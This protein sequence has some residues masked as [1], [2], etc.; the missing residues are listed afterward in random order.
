MGRIQRFWCY[1]VII[2]NVD[3]RMEG[4]QFVF[5]V[6]IVDDFVLELGRDIEDFE[7][8]VERVFLTVEGFGVPTRHSTSLNEI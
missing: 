6:W 2:V 1:L 5:V 4:L 7:S 8:M 3:C